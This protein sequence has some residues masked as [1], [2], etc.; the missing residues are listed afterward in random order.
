MEEY[1]QKANE[2]LRDG[3]SSPSFKRI[4]PDAV[5]GAL[6]IRIQVISTDIAQEDQFFGPDHDSRLRI[7]LV[8]DA[9]F[10]Y[11]YTMP[12]AGCGN[13]TYK[14]DNQLS[15]SI[16]A[17]I[18]PPQHT[19]TKLPVSRPVEV[20]PSQH[21]SMNLPV[22]RPV[23]EPQA[24]HTPVNLRVD[25]P[26][27]I[28]STQ[29]TPTKLPVNRPIEVPPAQHTPVNL[30]VNWPAETADHTP[31][32]V[33]SH[34]VQNSSG[35]TCRR[36]LQFS[37]P[38]V[39]DNDTQQ[40]NR[41]CCICK[42]II[43]PNDQL[44]HCRN[45]KCLV[46][47]HYDCEYKS[48]ENRRFVQ[49]FKK[50]EH[51]RTCKECNEVMG[52]ANVMC[53][54]CVSY[55]HIACVRRVPGQIA[56]DYTCKKCRV[57]LGTSTAPQRTI[58]THIHLNTGNIIK[59]QECCI[60]K[61][62][63]QPTDCLFNCKNS[64]CTVSTHYECEYKSRERRRFVRDFGKCEHCRTCKECNTVMGRANEMCKECV[65]Y[66]H[67]ACVRRAPGQIEGDY[68]CKECRV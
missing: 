37:P 20:P 3:H 68:V 10:H 43:K 22:D 65:G 42:L 9:S 48:R 28:P 44:F 32:E 1:C 29:H 53:K 4:I 61:Q 36:Q 12:A 16:Q 57:R 34:L 7:Q 33:P 26:A 50:C 5:A 51:C 35:L 47:T 27:E 46:L 38:N 41:E 54:V 45:T 23:E 64:K 6:A 56:G 15:A 17:E 11:D 59:K 40:E 62:E 63:I 31:I 8:Q 14:S 21:T 30:P 24:Q 19:P 58:S 25:R 55:A 18:P 60:C 52:R 2:Y 13:T 67:V 66:A 49:D 39:V